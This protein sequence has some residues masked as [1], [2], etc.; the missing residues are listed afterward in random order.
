MPG[1]KELVKKF[2]L[3]E[4]VIVIYILLTS[5]IMSYRTDVKVSALIVDSVIGWSTRS[6]NTYNSV[7]DREKRHTEEINQAMGERLS[8]AVL[9]QVESRGEAWYVYPKDKKR[10]FLGHEEDIYNV[11]NKLG[12]KANNE[13]LVNYQYFNKEFSQDL[14]GFVVWDLDN[15]DTAY[16]VKSQDKLG[17]FLVIRSRL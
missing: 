8:G 10:Y 4:L 17:Y 13:E 6:L 9:L 16:Y 15:K 11:L 12:K 1:G 14:L 2:I 5:T 7:I 3:F